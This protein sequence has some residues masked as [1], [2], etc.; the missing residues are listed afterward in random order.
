MSDERLT[1]KQAG[2]LTGRDPSALRHAI[3][4]GRLAAERV[5][6][7]RG[8]IWYVARA[9]LETYIA[10]ADAWP[11]NPRHRPHR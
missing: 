1:L 6:T 7:P 4:R 3:Q 10:E 5:E 8:P 2:E 11:A 9:N